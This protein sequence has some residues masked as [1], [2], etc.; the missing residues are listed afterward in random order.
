MTMSSIPLRESATGLGAQGLAPKGTVRWNLEVHVLAEAVRDRLRANAE[1]DL[2][3]VRLARA[4]REAGGDAR[5]A[6]LARSCGT[7]VRTLE[8]RFRESVGL[9]PKQY[10]RIVRIARVF[11]QIARTGSSWA[12]VAAECGYYDQA[13]LVDDCH[14]VLGRSPERFVRDLTNVSS[15]EIG[16][17]FENHPGVRAP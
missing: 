7:T 2:R 15:L 10:Q 11:R 6:A 14:D 13:H 17:I 5:L 4:I 3:A 16:L 9:A 1:L 12:Q 8:R